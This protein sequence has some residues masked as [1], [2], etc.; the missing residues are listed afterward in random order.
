M[1]YWLLSAFSLCL[2]ELVSLAFFDFGKHAQKV[3][4][5]KEIARI[6]VECES[7]D[8]LGKELVFTPSNLIGYDDGDIAKC[9][10]KDNFAFV[11][12]IPEDLVAHPTYLYDFAAQTITC[13]YENSEAS[14]FPSCEKIVPTKKHRC[15]DIGDWSKAQKLLLTGHSYLDRDKDGEACEALSRRSDRPEVGKV[16]IRNCYDGDTCT[17]SD[18]EKIRLACIDTPELRGKE[19]VQMSAAGARDYV[20]NMIAGKTVSIRRI[21]QDKYGRTV[22]ELTFDGRNVQELLVQQ[23]HAKFFKDIQISARGHRKKVNQSFCDLYLDLAQW[24]HYRD[25][26]AVVTLRN[27]IELAGDS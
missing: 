16:T 6:K 13:V 23:G 17:S 5:A 1:K 9:T 22:G 27:V 12:I 19:R 3:S 10:E 21:T 4:A 24:D 8:L 7:N 25:R 20:N 15:A 18:G 2:R 14:E 11:S 26:A